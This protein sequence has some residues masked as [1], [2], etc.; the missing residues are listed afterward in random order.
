MKE[1]VGWL[2]PVNKEGASGWQKSI[3]QNTEAKILCSR[4]AVVFNEDG[5]K[6]EIETE[7]EY[8]IKGAPQKYR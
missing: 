8:G 3:P 7:V 2:P 5:T 6:T 4:D 1:L